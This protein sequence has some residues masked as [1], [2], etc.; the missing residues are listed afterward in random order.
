M[1]DRNDPTL[2]AYVLGELDQSE[3]DSIEAELADSAELREAVEEIRATAA[4]LSDALAAA[5]ATELHPAQ[6]RRIANELQSEHLAIL[7]S[8]YQPQR[9]VAR[10]VRRSF[11]FTMIVAASLLV[12]MVSVTAMLSTTPRAGSDVMLSAALDDQPE[13]SPSVDEQKGLAPEGTLYFLDD[14][15]AASS[16]ERFALNPDS[17]DGS[18]ESDQDRLSSFSLG[19]T[20]VELSLSSEPSALRIDLTQSL[21]EVSGSGMSDAPAA[22]AP[23]PSDDLSSTL[24][25]DI[26]TI[27]RVPADGTVLIGG[28][29]RRSTEPLAISDPQPDAPA[30]PAIA[31][32]LP[33]APATSPTSGEGREG[34][35]QSSGREKTVEQE[36]PAEAKAEPRSWRRV[37]ATPNASRLMVGDHDELPLEG[38]QANVIIDG[39]R[40]RVLLDC[41]YYNDR[42]QQLEGTFKLRLPDDASLYYFAFG[43]TS[44]EYRPLVDQLT[45]IGFLPEDIV[46]ASGTAPDDILK[47][48]SDSFG[49]VKEA[50]LVP[51]EKAAYA[52]SE[53]VRRR[54]DPALVEWSGA[55]VF[56]ARVF[57][58]LPHKLHR[59]VIGYDVNLQSEN[60]DLVYTLDL[61]ADARQ[62]TVDLNVA[63]I[64][65]V[66]IEV[67]PQ[68]KPT[69][70]D[71]RSFYHL[72][73]P[74][75]EAITVR[76][77]R[78]GSLLVAGRDD[79]AGEFFAARFTPDLPAEIS[80]A[81]SPNAIF[82]VDTSLS[83]NPDKFSVWLKLL[84]TTLDKNR[85]SIRSFAVL[86]FNIEAHWWQDGLTANTP[87]NVAALLEYCQTLSLEGATD[88][89]LALAEATSPTTWAAGGEYEQPDLFLLSDGAVTWGETN[90]HLMAKSLKSGTGGT[91]F[92][93][94]T[95]LT[96]TATGVLEH[97]T[98]ESGGAVFSVATEDE[99]ERAATAY[100]NRPWQL[101]GATVAGGSDLLTAG[102]I[103]SVYPGQSLLLAGRGRPTGDVELTL[104]RGDEQRTVRVTLQHWIESAAAARLYG[105]VAVGQLE[106]LAAATEDVAIAYA[107]HFRVTGQ[108]CSLLMLES[109]ADYERFHI[110]PEDDVFV[111]KSTP[112]EPL[113]QRKLAELG[114]RLEDSK[115]AVVSWLE[116][117][118]KVP[119]VEFQIS[120][121]LRLAIERMPAESFEVH[122]PRLVT[123]SRARAD[124]PAEYVELL[125][126]PQLDYD[127]LTAEAQRRL[128]TLGPADALRALSSLVENSPGDTVVASD[129]AFSAIAWNLAGQAYPL[130]RRVALA[131]PYQPHTYEA[132]AQCL[133]E[134]GRADLAM[135]F[136]EVAV[137]GTWNDRYGEANRI[138]AVEYLHLLRRIAAGELTSSVPDY[139]QAR[140]DS[141]QSTLGLGQPDLIVTLMWN[142][143]RT[144]VD[145]HVLE[146]SG[147]E[148]SYQNPQIPGGGNIT[149][150]VTGGYGP[151]MYVLPQGQHG[152]YAVMANYFGSDANRTQVR[153]K[154]YLTIYES[155]GTR[156]ERVSKKTVVLN[157]T[158]EKRDVATVSVEK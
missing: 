40:A 13:L 137:T 103:R 72:S 74:Q 149:R 26:R 136:Y 119:G 148:C 52:Y 142:T 50:R 73:S 127:A 91:L 143:D 54:V 141:L 42:D 63:S 85:D 128:D 24:Y 66:Q 118:E 23:E 8:S 10:N 78:P 94:Q 129:V 9:D 71:G 147:Q 31:S 158:Q 51:R 48:R 80:Q 116:K 88:L 49:T 98:R 2:T 100:R 56:N 132:L 15:E 59:I 36:T 157:R 5:P 89:E 82:L 113:V 93:Y 28:I 55:G 20:D 12:A 75:D 105:Q 14:V 60:D 19:R 155:F 16:S 110:K 67:T 95:G 156:R 114:D 115:A 97:L 37:K 109:D 6:R 108:S 22:I 81:G 144:D 53:T 122:V 29:Q 25:S 107:R 68:V 86:F 123:E 106:S 150:D 87:E 101:L 38:V 120:T 99:I 152:K 126:N 34:Q 76:L 77:R 112:A 7:R 11:A 145:L 62:R 18:S 121:A 146:P 154:V 39:F 153:T 41:Y 134:I 131:R 61:P 140:L 96:G 138:V 17:R 33:E 32:P 117:L 4:L 1:R 104:Q 139:A 130:L 79:L 124:V 44:F 35:Q 64:A 151:E 102:R 46:R 3:R 65:G 58:L 43:D 57:P 47:A 27:I 90:L 70:S 111:V 133:A 125:A 135:I 21:G 84:E 30:L 83:S 92:A 45:S 69:V